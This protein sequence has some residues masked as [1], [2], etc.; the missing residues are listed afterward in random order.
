[1]AKEV[2]SFSLEPDLRKEVDASIER[3]KQS[4]AEGAEEMN[5][6]IWM[7][8]AVRKKLRRE[9]AGKRKEPRGHKP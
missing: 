1:M 4:G 6:S 2:V 9:S 5:F 7:R 3:F 8:D